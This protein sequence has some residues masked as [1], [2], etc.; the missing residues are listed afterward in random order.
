MSKATDQAKNR[1][2]NMSQLV[3]WFGS[4]SPPGLPWHVDDSNYVPVFYKGEFQFNC[5]PKSRGFYCLLCDVLANGQPEKF[6]S[7]LRDMDVVKLVP[8]RV[9]FT[10]DRN[11]QSFNVNVTC[12]IHT[13]T[14][15]TP[16]GQ[17]YAGNIQY[18]DV[19][20]SENKT[21]LCQILQY[22]KK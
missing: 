20:L 8:V 15:A 17:Y 14:S 10:D 5:P 13:S 6:S 4:E 9:V 3:A 18:S 22:K 16:V 2:N 12:T 19:Q 7:D 11:N 1:I 21:R